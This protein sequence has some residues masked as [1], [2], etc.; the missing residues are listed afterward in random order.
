MNGF[1]LVVIE[2]R[3]AWWFLPKKNGEFFSHCTGASMIP[4][5]GFASQGS[6]LEGIG[7]PQGPKLPKLYQP[8]CDQ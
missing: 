3:K 5:I 1:Y 2:R 4:E 7:F 8:A 6:E